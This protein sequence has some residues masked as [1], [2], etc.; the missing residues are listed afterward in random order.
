MSVSEVVVMADAEVTWTPPLL[1]HPHTS[2]CVV[3]GVDGS[4]G[5]KRALA[6]A[7]AVASWQ[8]WTLHIVHTWHTSYPIAPYV[9]DFSEMEAAAIDGA[10]QVVRDAEKEVLGDNC[11]LDIRRSI[12]EGPAARA[13]VKESEGADL[14]VV[15]SRGLGG[16]SSLS[17]GSVGQACVHHA[18]CPVL[19]VR[20][21][22]RDDQ[23]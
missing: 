14:L 13:L 23:P 19:I 9:M 18:H 3:V 16:F 8:G 11:P 4:E 17:L 5:A 22:S 12:D 20:P 6:Y 21:H 10:E 1:S 2:G 15:G 7:A